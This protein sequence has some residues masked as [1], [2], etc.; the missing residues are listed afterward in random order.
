[1][2]T[3]TSH[4]Y[5]S[6]LH[7]VECAKCHMDFGILPFFEKERRR[8]HGTFYC[9]AGH[10]NYY[11][12]KSDIEQVRERAQRADDRAA[13]LIAQRDQ[14]DAEAAHQR[15]RAAAYKGQITKARKRFAHGVCPVEGCRR[16]FDN[17]GAHMASKHADLVSADR[18]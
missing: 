7:I 10:R 2:S 15:R 14:A 13:R 5:T 1:M 18:G 11:P 8:D 6:T 3:Q 12:Q 17:L 16:H 9:P 4:S